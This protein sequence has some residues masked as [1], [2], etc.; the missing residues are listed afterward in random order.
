MHDKEEIARKK[1]G[2]GVTELRKIAGNRRD[3]RR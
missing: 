2:S 3:W 1:N